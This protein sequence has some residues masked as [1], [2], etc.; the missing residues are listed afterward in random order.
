MQESQKQAIAEELELPT[1]STAAIRDE[2]SSQL[3]SAAIYEI[4]NDGHIIIDHKYY[5]GAEYVLYR[6]SIWKPLPVFVINCSD[7][8]EQLL[9]E[10]EQL[11]NRDPMLFDKTVTEAIQSLMESVNQRY[12]H[13]S[14]AAFKVSWRFED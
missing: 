6:V 4:T 9:N 1:L 5:T 13:V 12:Y 2:L 7:L 3:G 10:L 8:S 14:G 11:K